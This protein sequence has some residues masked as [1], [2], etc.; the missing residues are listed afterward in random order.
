MVM[1][2]LRNDINACDLGKKG[3]TRL[4]FFSYFQY[5]KRKTQTNYSQ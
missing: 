2:L 3:T 4:V 1:Y 5:K